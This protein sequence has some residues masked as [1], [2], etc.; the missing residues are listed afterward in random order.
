MIEFDEGFLKPEMEELIEEVSEMCWGNVKMGGRKPYTY[1]DTLLMLKEFERKS[2]AFDRFRELLETS[3][4]EP[5]GTS[6]DVLELLDLIH[7]EVNVAW[8]EGQ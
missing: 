2:L 8:S 1:L 6:V 4:V 5:F 3:T 7:K